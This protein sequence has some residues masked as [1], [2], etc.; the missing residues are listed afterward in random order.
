VR[1]LADFDALAKVYI[2]QT[3]SPE[4][5][6]EGQIVLVDDGLVDS[7]VAHLEFN[8]AISAEALTDNTV[9]VT[10]NYVEKPT[11]EKCSST[12]SRSYHFYYLQTTKI[13]V[14]EEKIVQ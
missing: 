2:G 5:F 12:I 11:V 7:C 14:F 8:E 13:L 4:N 6:D 9:K 3:I 10:L 1:T